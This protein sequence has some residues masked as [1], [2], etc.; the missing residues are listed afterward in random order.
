MSAGDPQGFIYWGAAPSVPVP[1]PVN[2]SNSTTS[3]PFVIPALLASQVL[4]VAGGLY[5]AGQS[6]T[7]SDGT[8]TLTGVVTAIGGGTVTITVTAIT[9]GV[10][11]NTMASGATVKGYQFRM[12]S[13]TTAML[14]DFDG[15]A[16][17]YWCICVPQQIAPQ[18]NTVRFNDSPLDL[19]P[20]VDVVTG[21]DGIVYDVYRSAVASI[22]FTGLTIQ[23]R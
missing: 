14:F 2:L 3:A 6:L 19:L 21:S 5:L 4:S 8:H 22:G 20:F 18:I 1:D 13:T 12:D 11:G 15:A 10:A 7:V 17:G 23:G 16:A 9:L